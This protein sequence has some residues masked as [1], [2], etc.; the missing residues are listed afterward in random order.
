MQG[1]RGTALWPPRAGRCQRI[2]PSAFDHVSVRRRQWSTPVNPESTVANREVNPGPAHSSPAPLRP[3]GPQRVEAAPAPAAA[4]PPAGY[5]PSSAGAP[6]GAAPCLHH[7]RQLHDRQPHDR[8][9]AAGPP[10]RPGHA[11]TNAKKKT[12]L[13]MKKLPLVREYRQNIRS[14][15]PLGME[16]TRRRVPPKIGRWVHYK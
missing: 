15:T 3:S 2:R 5:P 6:R 13:S 10:A 12:T 1:G 14:Q 9:A 4:G 11:K 16:K 7:D 8:Q